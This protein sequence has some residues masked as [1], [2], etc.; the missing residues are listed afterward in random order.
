MGL[1]PYSQR[2]AQGQFWLNN[3]DGGVYYNQKYLAHLLLPGE[4]I[5]GFD[6][7]QIDNFV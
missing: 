7:L 1:S 6:F 3:V 4:E 5:G 2:E